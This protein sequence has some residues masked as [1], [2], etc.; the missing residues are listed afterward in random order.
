MRASPEAARE[1][2][3]E[4]HALGGPALCTARVCRFPCGAPSVRKFNEFVFQIKKTG[5]GSGGSSVKPRC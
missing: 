3:R 2:G 1:R 4:S 5:A